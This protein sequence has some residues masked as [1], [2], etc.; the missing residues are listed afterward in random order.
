[1]V[2]SRPA[3]LAPRSLSAVTEG[4]EPEHSWRGACCAAVGVTD[5]VPPGRGT[6]RA[7]LDVLHA[8]LVSFAFGRAVRELEAQ[9]EYERV[10]REKLE[11]Q[12][13]DYRAEINQLRED[14]GKSCSASD[15]SAVSATPAPL[16][17]A[18]R[19]LPACVCLFPLLEGTVPGNT[20]ENV[21]QL[22]AQDTDMSRSPICP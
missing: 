3:P 11:S 20:R 16:A 7:A 6:A 22:S 12:L 4:P 19:P 8:P 10:R 1:M 14:R 2:P 13:D 5:L 18:Q 21:L 15:T 9:L 17:M